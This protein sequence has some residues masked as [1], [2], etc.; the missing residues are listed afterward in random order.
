MKQM[1]K[2]KH[3]SLALLGLLF[4]AMVTGCA[5]S[6]TAYEI[7]KVKK[8]KGQAV[9]EGMNLYSIAGTEYSFL[10]PDGARTETE[11]E[12]VYLYPENG[13]GYVLIT[14][15]ELLEPVTPGEYFS[16]CDELVQSE[17]KNVKSTKIQEV[18]VEDKYLYLTR[19]MGKKD[20]DE[21]VIDRYVEF[22]DDCMVEY[23]AFSEEAGLL[24]T[25]LYYAVKTL[26]LRTDAYAGGF[27][28]KLVK[29]TEDDTRISIMLPDMLDVKELTIGYL[30]TG[31]D[32]LVL[33]IRYN[34]DDDGNAVPD[35]DTF[36]RLASEKDTF[37]SDL[38]GADYAEFFEGSVVE[39]SGTEFYR[40]PM[41]MLAGERQMD[42]AVYLADHPDGGCLFMYYAVSK[43]NVNHKELLELF[44]ESAETI[45]WKEE[46][47]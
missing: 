25:E 29:Y 15:Q 18:D 38:I 6:D 11:D 21:Y 39:L 17:L 7:N 32:V 31:E 44:R 43:D 42:G 8:E 14:R 23:T 19:Y 40:Y 33:C 41:E 27:S 22:Y 30:A 46:K 12:G 13:G 3:G 9:A 34:E 5:S 36:I 35:R 16:A 37:V 10:Y 24:D 1:K 26:S 45:R 4:G 20:G 47:E 28:E 2:W